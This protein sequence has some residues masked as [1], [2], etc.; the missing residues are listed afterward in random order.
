MVY[1][2]I[3]IGAGPAGCAAAIILARSGLNAL[4]LETSAF[5]RHRPGESL[6]PGVEPIF[7]ALGI[8]SAVKTAGFVR[9][10]GHR[11]VWSLNA[12]EQLERFGSDDQGE[13]KGYQAWRPELDQILLQQAQAQGVTVWQPCQARAPIF[14]GNQL[15]G[16]DTD[17][18]NIQTRYVLD[19]SGRSQWLLRKLGLNTLKYSPQLIVRYGYVHCFQ[20]PSIFD[21]PLMQ[22]DITGWTWLARV[23]QERCAWVRMQ[24]DGIDPG[25]NW[26][27]PQ[28]KD[29][30][31]F[32][33]SKGENMTW[34]ISETLAT[35]SW[36]LM[37]DA[38]VVL[39]PA[40][41]HGV[42][43]ALMSGMQVAH[44]ITSTFRGNISKA[45]AAGLYSRWL[46]EWFYHDITRLRELYSGKSREPALS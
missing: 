32:C 1:D 27:P 31:E 16:L 17:W 2:A 41:S 46:R 38:A 20:G 10:I 4:L 35:E 21:I 33:P 29:W 25:R 39:D 6:H 19:A 15:I 9:H 40:S 45:G 7:A 30:V 8:A 18:G 26:R 43:R 5:P 34:R 13:W 14:N 36:F 12:P 22:R 23:R 24:F 28:L 44:L 37:G 3:I 42:L 11:I